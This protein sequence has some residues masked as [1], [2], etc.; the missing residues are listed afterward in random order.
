VLA[1]HITVHTYL[2]QLYLSH[3]SGLTKYESILIR[4]YLEG[5]IKIMY[6]Q[7]DADRLQYS[8]GSCNQDRGR[9]KHKTLH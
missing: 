4:S 5:M 1:C 7:G 6:M 3:R 9:H 2:W 8:G